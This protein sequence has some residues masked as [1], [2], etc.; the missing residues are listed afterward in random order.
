MDQTNS[1]IY[2]PLVPRSIEL[3]MILLKSSVTERQ[4][5]AQIPK[6]AIQDSYETH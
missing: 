6:I 4:A 5:W 1:N 2:G 3:L